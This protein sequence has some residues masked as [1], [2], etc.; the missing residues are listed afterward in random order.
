MAEDAKVQQLEDEFK[1]LKNEIKHVLTDIEEFILD[2][3]NPFRAAAGPDG[4]S[5]G[6]VVSSGPASATADGGPQANGRPATAGLQDGEPGEQPSDEEADPDGRSR[7][8]GEPPQGP[9]SVPSAREGHLDR[10]PVEGQAMSDDA[11]APRVESPPSEAV[12]DAPSRLD[13]LDRATIVALGQ[14]V[15]GATK[16]VGETR[17]KTI[18]ACQAADSRPCGQ[19]YQ[20]H[21]FFIVR[22]Y[23]TYA[24]PVDTRDGPQ[25]TAVSVSHIL[26]YLDVAIAVSLY[27]LG[28][29]DP[30]A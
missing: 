4:P 23:E 30:V 16:R 28:A 11:R 2:A 8:D 22:K 7:A 17:I 3:R 27:L 9:E 18:L 1:L 14:W 29:A 26:E 19:E 15:R 21:P 10:P 13:Q 5:I 25:P 20:F 24:K 12:G 6:V